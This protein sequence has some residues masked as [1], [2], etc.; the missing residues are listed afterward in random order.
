[1]VAI[2]GGIATILLLLV[3]SRTL[4]LTATGNSSRQE[5]LRLYSPQYQLPVCSNL[6]L[7]NFPS[8]RLCLYIYPYPMDFSYTNL[9]SHVLSPSELLASTGSIR[10]ERRGR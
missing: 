6:H 7:L 8:Q 10:R 9:P 3:S 2:Y 5:T 4:P 1:M